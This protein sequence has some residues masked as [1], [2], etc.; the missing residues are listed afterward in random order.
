MLFADGKMNLDD[1]DG[2]MD[3]TIADAAMLYGFPLEFFHDVLTRWGKVHR[4]ELIQAC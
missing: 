4:H 3:T 1:Q 2:L